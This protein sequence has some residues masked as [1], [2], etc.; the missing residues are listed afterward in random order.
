MMNDC[1]YVKDNKTE[2]CKSVTDNE[3]KD[4]KGENENDESE[5]VAASF[6]EENEYINFEQKVNKDDGTSEDTFEMNFEQNGNNDDG[7]SEKAP[8]RNI[9]KS[10]DIEE[11]YYGNQ[12]V[13][14]SN[15]A[16]NNGPPEILLN[17]LLNRN[18][19]N[20][21]FND[22]NEP[23]SEYA[24]RLFKIPLKAKKKKIFL[25]NI[26]ITK[27]TSIYLTLHYIAR[28]KEYRLVFP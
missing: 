27:V 3:K 12:E 19:Y 20:I 9:S 26:F 5:Y 23:S 24:V 18:S 25:V 10:R 16:A 6:V 21:Y 17:E 14:D 11:S 2:N 13:K 7:T 4:T 1:S 15:T 8:R 22:E 28:F